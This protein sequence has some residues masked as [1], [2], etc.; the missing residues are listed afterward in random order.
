MSGWASRRYGTTSPFASLV[1]EISDAKAEY[2]VTMSLRNACVTFFPERDTRYRSQFV[3]REGVTA[4][5]HGFSEYDMGYRRLATVRPERPQDR[6]SLAA[7]ERR[8]LGLAVPMSSNNLYHQAFHAVPAWEMLRAHASADT[9]LIPLVFSSAAF[10]RGGKAIKPRRWF[11]WEFTV[12]A[13]SNASSSALLAATQALVEARCTC[14]DR[15]EADA[16]AFNPSARG[17]TSRLRAFRARALYNNAV[18][19]AGAVDRHARRSLLFVSRVGSRRVATN[20]ASLLSRLQAATARVQ[21]VVLEELPFAEQMSLVA[22]SAG[23]IAVHGQALA[24]MLFLPTESARTAVVEILIWSGRQRIRINDCYQDWAASLQVKYWR[25]R[26]EASV[27]PPT[28]KRR[29]KVNPLQL[30]NECNVTVDADRLLGVVR[31]AD[32]WT[33]GGGGDGRGGVLY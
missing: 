26:S 11:A 33:A 14:F 32:A 21:R 9:T 5:L 6:T 17:A 2:Y 23:L 22:S 27:C 4:V 20:E 19:N 30:L 7:C 16:S 8:S 13:L 29:S 24:W 15:V 1:G 10:G 18:A 25:V 3:S 12:R 31:L 28:D